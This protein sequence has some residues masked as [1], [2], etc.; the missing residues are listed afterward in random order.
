MEHQ[1][2]FDHSCPHRGQHPS[3]RPDATTRGTSRWCVWNPKNKKRISFVMAGALFLAMLVAAPSQAKAR[4]EDYARSVL[5][6]LGLS[7]ADFGWKTIPDTPNTKLARTAKRAL[8]LQ[9][10]G[11]WSEMAMCFAEMLDE[12]AY[13]DEEEDIEEVTDIAASYIRKLQANRKVFEKRLSAD[14]CVLEP[15]IHIQDSLENKVTVALKGKHY[16]TC[17]KAQREGDYLALLNALRLQSGDEGTPHE[18]YPN[19]DKVRWDLLLGRSKFFLACR[20]DLVNPD[21]WDMKGEPRL[22]ALIVTIADSDSDQTP[23][24]MNWIAFEERLPTDDG[25]MS[26]WFWDLGTTDVCILLTKFNEVYLP[27]VE[28]IEDKIS[29]FREK[30]EKGVLLGDITDDEANARVLEYARSETASFLDR[31]GGIGG[32]YQEQETE[33]QKQLDAKAEKSLLA[34]G[35]NA[36]LYVSQSLLDKGVSVAAVIRGDGVQK[37]KEIQTARDTKDWRRIYA[38]LLPEQG[39][40]PAR[41]TEEDIAKALDRWNGLDLQMAIAIKPATSA[42]A[43]TGRFLS[44]VASGMGNFLGVGN[45]SSDSQPWLVGTFVNHSIYSIPHSNQNEQLYLVRISPSAG[46]FFVVDSPKNIEKWNSRYK[47]AGKPEE[48][49]AEFFREYSL[50]PHEL[51]VGN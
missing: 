17:L 9:A 4:E 24:A 19:P 39:G 45:D 33:R 28:E 36:K 43:R 10:A 35:S 47:S 12:L 25:Y 30:V 20:T 11:R 44:N 16:A 42:S 48:V 13:Y 22:G 38:I 14:A 41:I 7:P 5:S 15:K 2:Q 26:H 37:L 1:A 27:S 8:A 31:M 49:K 32:A 29:Q 6:P 51:K 3:A 50:V 23:V 40:G 34:L 46:D 18:V 21:K